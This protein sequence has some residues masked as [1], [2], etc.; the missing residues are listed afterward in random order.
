MP[1]I[2]M[3]CMKGFFEFAQAIK[4]HFPRASDV[5]SH[6]SAPFFSEY[7]SVIECQSG[8]VDEQFDE[9]FVA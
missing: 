6:E 9:F 7:G 2:Q 5:Q 3:L 4:D 8:F 1:E